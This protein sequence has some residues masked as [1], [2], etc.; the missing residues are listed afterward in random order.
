MGHPQFFL[1]PHPSQKAVEIGHPQILF[2]SPP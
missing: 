2:L 1:C